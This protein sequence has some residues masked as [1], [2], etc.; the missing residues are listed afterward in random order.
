MTKKP[1]FTTTTAFPDAHILVVDDERTMRRSLTEI[2]ERVGY[3][4]SAAASGQK[5][6]QYISER[7]IDVVI[8]DL[9]MAG[10][11]GTDVLRTARPI[12]PDTM[13]IILT[14]YGTLDS[15]I[16]GIRH[17]AFDYL[18]KPSPMK[19]IIHTVESSLAERQRRMDQNNPIA[20][21]E[22]ALIDLKGETQRETRTSTTERFLQAPGI[23]LD[24]SRHLV[25]VRGDP[26][27]LTPTEFDILT[28]MMR[29]QNQVISCR[30]IVAQIRG[31]DL[32]ERDARTLLRSHI[33]RLR[34]KTELNPS[35]PALIKVVRGR[36]YL[37]AAQESPSAP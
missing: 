24:T 37:F 18:L 13:F 9:K 23:T 30:E 16:I 25:V 32:D 29:H 2:F 36:G 10:M 34:Q 4:T 5:A 14:A 20:L 33:H 6:L 19:E 3:R 8:L 27:E 11:D 1:N 35:E 22:Q 17:G 7:D 12:A 21:L 15:A 28:Y 31:H 26:V